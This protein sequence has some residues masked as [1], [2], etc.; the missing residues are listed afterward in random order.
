MNENLKLFLQRFY[1]DEAL[2]ARFGA[3]KSEDEAYTLA[4][5]V[6]DGFTKEE[7]VETMSALNQ[8]YNDGDISREDL[9]KVGGG[10]D[11]TDIIYTNVTGTIMI[12]ATSAA[13]AAI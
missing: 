10:A 5:S 6:Q 4:S 13:A 9:A 1:E 11:R 8:A 12:S 3:C 7:F 2:T